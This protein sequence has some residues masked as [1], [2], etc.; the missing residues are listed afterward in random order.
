MRSPAVQESPGSTGPAA[1]L[2]GA[3]AVGGFLNRLA[4]APTRARI[5]MAVGELAASVDSVLKSEP[6]AVAI[7][8][9]EAGRRAG[10]TAA[11]LSVLWSR[12]GRSTCLIDLASGPAA[13]G[14]ALK[15]TNPD[16]AAACEIAESG[17]LL[18]SLSRLHGSI[19]LAAAI[20]AGQ[21]DVLGL[22]S[23]GKLAA[24]VRSLKRNHS[25]VILATPLLET[26]FPFL[27]LDGVCDRLVLAV[28]RGSTRGGP[29]REIAEQ[30]LRAG[31]RP[32]EVIWYD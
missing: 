7:S 21:A 30:A 8:A 5:A 28:A 3:S 2:N 18:D 4:T 19:P 15:G 12:W 14:G 20:A 16:L 6:A 31:L 22:L 11:A 29:L 27:S 26:G 1:T 23:S 25:R 24:L 9:I 17:A 32:L 13:L 10:E